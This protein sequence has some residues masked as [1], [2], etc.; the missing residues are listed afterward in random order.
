MQICRV[1][2]DSPAG[3]VRSP[4]KGPALFVCPPAGDLQC[5]IVAVDLQCVIHRIEKALNGNSLVIAL[6]RQM[7]A[8]L[9]ESKPGL[10]AVVPA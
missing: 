10:H 7:S 1:I 3:K 5:V 9:L 6:A 4:G 8:S 2:W